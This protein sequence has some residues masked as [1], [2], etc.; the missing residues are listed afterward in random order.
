MELV[1]ILQ[2]LML[3][4]AVSG[5]EKNMAYKMKSYFEKFTDHVT[6]DR[7]GNTMA[8]FDGKSKDAPRMMIFAHMD[9]LGFI[10]RKIEQNGLIQVDRLGGIP[11]KVLPALDVSVFTIDGDTI[12]GVIGNKAHHA[13]AP[14]EKYK[15]DLV[16]SLFIDIGAKS[17]KEVEQS[18]VHIGC[19]ICYR[20]SFTRLRNG[21]VAG[22]AVDNRG[23][24]SVL[25]K[26]AEYF[27]KHQPVA[28][29]HLVGTVWEEF[30][31]RGAVFAARAIK[32]DLAI[33]LDVVLPGDTPD[34]QSRYDTALSSGP[35]VA[36]YN[37]HGR[38]T[39]NGTIA[40]NGLYKH[41]LTCAQESELPLQEFAALGMLTDCAYVQM[42]GSYIGCLDMGFPARYTHSP[43][44][45]CDPKDLENLFSLVAVMASTIDD[46]FYIPRL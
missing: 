39:L 45:T 22:T 38:G 23:G 27:S 25:V 30:N 10:V 40:H 43:V 19:P 6:M 32:P 36:L 26:L 28:T 35:A 2:D 18:G 42:E 16:T 44:E 3:T 33:G 21:L 46:T 7:A 8:R 13:T 5:Y 1:D 4:P 15:V 9:Q 31:I 17:K 14:E 12:P 24:C 34:L 41:A 11:E 29:V 37:F 20:P